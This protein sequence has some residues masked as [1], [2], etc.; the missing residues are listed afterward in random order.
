M[1]L[2]IS[3]GVR[4]VTSAFDGTSRGMHFTTI[5]FGDSEFSEALYSVSRV[6][7]V[8]SEGIQDV[9]N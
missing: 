2:G 7:Q 6:L 4:S 9:Q 3:K 5:N 8:V 1:V